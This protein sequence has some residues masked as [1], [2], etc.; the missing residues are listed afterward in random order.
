VILII[1]IPLGTKIYRA[2]QD[3]SDGRIQVW[4]I[5]Q[6][7]IADRPFF[8]FGYGRFERE[9]NLY[10]AKYFGS[11]KATQEEIENSA[12]VKMAYNEP[13]ENA[14]EG[15]IIGMVLFTGLL[16]SLIIVEIKRLK[17]KKYGHKPESTN[18]E[19]QTSNL[20]QEITTAF[21][22]TCAFT[23]MSLVNFTVQAIPVMALFVLYAAILTTARNEIPVSNTSNHNGKANPNPSWLKWGLA[24]LLISAGSC[25]LIIN[26]HRAIAQ[27]QNRNAQKYLQQGKIMEALETFRSLEDR[28]SASESFRQNYGRA[29]MKTKNYGDALVQL[30]EAAK[31]T[32]DPDLYMNIGHCN[33]MLRNIP[34]AEAN[35]KTAMFIQP[36]L[37]APRFALMQKYKYTKDTVRALDMAKGIL[38]L[39][40][41]VPSKKV[42]FYKREAGKYLQK[43]QHRKTKQK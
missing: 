26:S 43:I 16:I 34:E 30:T 38:A 7:M 10:Q 11:G 19:P 31:Y 40:P 27:I 13:I 21:A 18:F 23:V 36:S 22:G 33:R 32:S 12:H 28:L 3:S 35:Y 42:D 2:K 4:K 14:V 24:I 8:G 37:F 20:E 5:S 15:G 1:S 17:N 25:F 29:L 39:K 41:K 6:K 9:Y